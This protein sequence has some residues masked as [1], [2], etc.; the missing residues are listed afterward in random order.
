[1]VDLN[2]SKLYIFL[3][4]LAFNLAD[5]GAYVAGELIGETLKAAANP[6]HDDL[7]YV[8]ILDPED[9]DYTSRSAMTDTAVAKIPNAKVTLA[10][11]SKDLFHS[12]VMGYYET[13]VPG[14]YDFMLRDPNNQGD[15]YGRVTSRESVNTAGQSAKFG[16]SSQGAGVGSLGS[17]AIVTDIEI[18]SFSARNTRSRLTVRYRD[19]IG[20]ID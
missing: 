15:V 3:S 12:R 16:A 5:G 14:E 18:D 6:P 9:N 10:S 1:M 11:G 13:Y 8:N 19:I 2:R 4:S 7:F 17:T 20:T